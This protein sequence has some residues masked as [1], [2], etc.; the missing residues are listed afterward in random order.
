MTKRDSIAVGVLARR[1]GDVINNVP[2]VKHVSFFESIKLRD[3]PAPIQK[4]VTTPLV[5]ARPADRRRA[6]QPE[7]RDGARGR[8]RTSPRPT[9]AHAQEILDGGRAVPGRRA[10]AGLLTR[11]RGPSSSRSRTKPLSSTMNARPIGAERAAA[12]TR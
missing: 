8:A 6:D 2:M 3:K 11:R 1:A 7:G 5:V 4:M 9:C 12:S 10:P